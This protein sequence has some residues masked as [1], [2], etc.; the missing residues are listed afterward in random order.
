M[1]VHRLLLCFLVAGLLGFAL[2]CSSLWGSIGAAAGG[3]AGA[4]V[5][6]PLGAAAGAAAGGL[7]GSALGENSDLR[8]GTLVGEDAL[9]KELLR[10]KG[11]ALAAKAK[12][13][14]LE[15]AKWLV[16]LAVLGLWAFRNRE[17]LFN[18]GPGWLGRVLHAI[19]GGK[20]GKAK[21]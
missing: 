1:M 7:A 8:D 20:V 16:V 21:S 10:W 2:S 6:G 19:V 17:H 3:A 5:G 15:R 18:F 14:Y 13:D 11:E 4:V 9:R 12:V